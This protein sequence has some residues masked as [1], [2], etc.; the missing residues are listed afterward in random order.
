MNKI[1]PFIFIVLIS[2]PDIT[3]AQDASEIIK[4]AD[5]KA[6]KALR[7]FLHREKNGAGYC[8]RILIKPDR[9]IEPFGDQEVDL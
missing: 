9:S 3:L 5:D 2:L 8:F 6:K 7:P 1:L 4:K